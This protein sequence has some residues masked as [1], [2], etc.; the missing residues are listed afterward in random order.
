VAE[1]FPYSRFL[2]KPLAQS[3]DPQRE[4]E[5]AL[6]QFTRLFRGWLQGFFLF[7]FSLLL[8]PSQGSPV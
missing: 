8:F 1:R 4:G 3:N 6:F 5:K 2:G 7:P